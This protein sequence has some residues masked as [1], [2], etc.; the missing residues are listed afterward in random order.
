MVVAGLLTFLLILG[1]LRDRDAVVEIAIVKLAVARGSRVTPDDVEW[2][3][4]RG[5]P[6]GLLSVAVTSEAL[7]AARRDGLVAARTIPA[8]TLLGPGDLTRADEGG[9]RVMSLPLTR[10]GIPPGL[11]QPGDLVDVIGFADGTAEFIVTAAEVLHVTP[12][13]GPT[14]SAGSVAL[15]VDAP[16]SLRLA[17][18]LAA[19]D[20]QIVKVTD[21]TAADPDASYPPVEVTSDGS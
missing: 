6:D 2:L 12:S 19:A 3:S 5:A 11:L 9:V 21:A 20:I 14:S 1:V 16:A 18:A 10:T 4:W 8:A 17:W 15:A 13:G 7:D